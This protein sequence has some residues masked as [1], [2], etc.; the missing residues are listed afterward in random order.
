LRQTHSKASAI[1]HGTSQWRSAFS[2]LGKADR[3]FNFNG[4]AKLLWVENIEGSAMNFIAGL[5][6][7]PTQ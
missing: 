3:T 6:S 7:F 4:V 5:Q 2:F 1:S